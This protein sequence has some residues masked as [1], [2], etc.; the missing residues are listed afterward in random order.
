MSI[1]TEPGPGGGG[2][3]RLFLVLLAAVVGV[4][5]A[6]VLWLLARRPAPAPKAPPPPPR[7][8]TTPAP[9]PTPAASA[10]PEARAT[11]RP[12]PKR[13]AV[14]NVLRVDSDVPGANVFL[15]RKFLGT[16]P[17]ETRDFAPGTH[18]IN[19]SAEGYD[20]YGETVELA[21]G[22]NALTIRFKEVRLDERVD[23]VHKHGVG[24]C[25]GRL[26]AAPAGLRFE[27]EKAGDSFDVPLASLEP[28]QVDYL[29]RNLRVKQRGGKTWNFTADSADAL[30]SFQKAVEK[31]RARL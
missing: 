31:A 10:A 21:A 3:R 26:L 25:R 7:A 20:M 11:L 9:R 13:E 1:F 27:S 4:A 17:V 12:E 30:L 22:E 8:R 18:R 23:V 2:R 6:L 14:A 24:S 16:T 29:N 15:D 19:A 28:L 5:L